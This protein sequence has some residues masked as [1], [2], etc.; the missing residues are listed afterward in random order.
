MNAICAR[1]NSEFV[2]D[3][4]LTERR[5]VLMQLSEL[6]SF[7]E[8][9][10]ARIPCGTAG[11]HRIHRLL[12]KLHLDNHLRLDQRATVIVIDI[13]SCTILAIL[14]L[15]YHAQ[16]AINNREANYDRSM[17]CSVEVTTEGKLRD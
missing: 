14:C 12:E 3:A 7:L 8:L 2:R 1:C 10:V 13:G 17:T 16:A 9:K 6:W 11:S 4:N 15:G 5:R